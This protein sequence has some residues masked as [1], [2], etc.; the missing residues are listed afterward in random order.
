MNQKNQ[1]RCKTGQRLWD[2]FEEKCKAEESFGDAY[3]HYIVHVAFCP[4]CMD[5]ALKI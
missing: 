1:T 2:I 4:I 3:M 5:G